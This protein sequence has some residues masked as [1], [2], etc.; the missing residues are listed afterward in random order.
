MNHFAPVKRVLKRFAQDQKGTV[1][2]MSG[3]VAIP[4]FLMA[5]TAIDFARFNGAQTHVQ[6]ALDAAALAGASGKDLT[7]AERIAAAQA[8]FA[9]NMAH[10]VA[11]DRIP[12]VL[13]SAFWPTRTMKLRLCSITPVPCG[14]RQVAK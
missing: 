2:V 4:L 13:K 5:G 14:K 7:D 6:T 10:G 3:L 11:S 1:A 8:M 9:N 12:F